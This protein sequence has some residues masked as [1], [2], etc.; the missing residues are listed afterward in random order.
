MYIMYFCHCYSPLISFS[1][2]LTPAL[3]LYS[4]IQPTSR[5][6]ICGR[7]APTCVLTGTGKWRAVGEGWKRETTLPHLSHLY[8]ETNGLSGCCCDRGM[9]PSPICLIFKL[10][11]SGRGVR[12]SKPCCQWS[13]VRQTELNHKVWGWDPVAC[14]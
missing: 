2:Y 9:A 6:K 11:L 1:P 12:L 10:A 8:P 13:A 5:L 4:Q 14:V 3:V 7:G